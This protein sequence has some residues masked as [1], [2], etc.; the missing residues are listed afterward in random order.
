MAAA[1]RTSGT[2]SPLTSVLNWGVIAARRSDR[3]WRRACSRARAEARA[4]ASVAR[5]ALDAEAEYEVAVF[6]FA[7]RAALPDAVVVT[8]RRAA[9]F[10]CVEAAADEAG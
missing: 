5:R 2:T 8:G 4:L 7:G 3:L 10:R 6:F 1:A 9:G